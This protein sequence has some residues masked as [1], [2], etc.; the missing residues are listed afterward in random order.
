V[1]PGVYVEGE[2]GVRIEDLITFDAE[3]GTVRRL[4]SFP[5]EVVVVGG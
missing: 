5:R 4:T 2:L 3:A 1:E